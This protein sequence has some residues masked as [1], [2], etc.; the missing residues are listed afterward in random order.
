MLTAAALVAFA[1]NSILCRLALREAAIDPASFTIIR[2]LSGAI[3]LLLVTARM[4]RSV[5]I[6]AGSWTSAV[7]LTLYALPFAFAYTQLSAGTGALILFGC[8][9]ITMLVAAVGTGERPRP[10]QW[11][12]V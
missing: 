11:A 6:H 10:R 5:S 12:G 3:A 2:F 8:V 1:A 4:P 7:V 9:Q